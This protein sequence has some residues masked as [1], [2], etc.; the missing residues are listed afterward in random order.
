MKYEETLRPNSG[1]IHIPRLKHTGKHF[2]LSRG[3]F[4]ANLT[5]S[6]G[7]VERKPNPKMHINGENEQTLLTD[8]GELE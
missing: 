4:E 6:V 5:A 8:R 3:I 1:G 2:S 7:K